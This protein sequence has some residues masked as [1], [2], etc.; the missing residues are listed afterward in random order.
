MA[1]SN[2]AQHIKD[3]GNGVRAFEEAA[4]EAFR[5]AASQPELAV[6]YF[7]LASEA[8][9]FVDV[10]DRMPVTKAISDAAQARFAEH[11]AKLDSAQQ[12]SAE[13]IAALNEIV[14]EILADR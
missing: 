14:S 4:D 8:A 2:I 7:V 3:A 1:F 13:T 6:A 11:A 10:Y 5:A 9:E 12:D